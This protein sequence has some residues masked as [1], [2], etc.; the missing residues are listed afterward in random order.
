MSEKKRGIVDPLR[1]VDPVRK[2]PPAPAARPSGKKRIDLD[3]IDRDADLAIPNKFSIRTKHAS[4]NI[5]STT[6]TTDGEAFDI[7]ADC[8]ADLFVVHAVATMLL[9]SGIGVR[10]FDRMWNVPGEETPASTFKSGDSVIWFTEKPLDEGA[11]VLARIMQSP[12]AAS[13]LHQRGV[14]VMM[15]TS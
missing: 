7:L 11:L 6:A 15:T 9:A 4:F 5:T 12:Y 8:V 13:T 3:E 10:C 14:V 1:T 2:P